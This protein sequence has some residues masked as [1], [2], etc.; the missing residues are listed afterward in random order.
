MCM[1]TTWLNAQKMRAL[2]AGEDLPATQCLSAAW[3]CRRQGES[4]AQPTFLW[5][6]CPFLWF[7]LSP[8]SASH[9]QLLPLGTEMISFS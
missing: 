1:R 2:M 4:E 6:S 5:F 7:Q 9:H 8:G 3:M